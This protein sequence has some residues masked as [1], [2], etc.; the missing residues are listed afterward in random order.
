[1]TALSADAAIRI[2]G[3]PKT[4]KFVLDTSAAQT[5]YK[6]QP[7]IVDQS[8]DATGP[9]VAFIDT[10][11]PVVAATD[12]FMGIAAEAKAVALGDAETL[13]AS[14]I[15]AWIEPTIVGFKST[16][17]TNGADNG[18]T[19][20]MSDSGTLSTGAG[21]SPM[22]GTLQFVEDGYAYVKLITAICT[23]A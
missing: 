14:G 4:H 6:G 19:V 18:K 10:T 17:F 13:A 22:I 5:V 12:V 11:H 21:D 3:T 7:L 1:M 23:G 9:L 8:A 20:Y 16:V 2:Y 15:E